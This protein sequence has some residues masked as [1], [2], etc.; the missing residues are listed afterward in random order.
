MSTGC[1]KIKHFSFFVLYNSIQ[2]QGF[3]SLDEG[4]PV[5]FEIRQSPKGDHAENDI[6]IFSLLLFASSD[7]HGT[8]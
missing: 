2:G 8:N 5:K 7:G 6:A 4:E 3:K 1:R